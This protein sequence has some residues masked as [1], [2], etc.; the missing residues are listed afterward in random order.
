MSC[1]GAVK[2]VVM[3]N[4]DCLISADLN[5]GFNDGI[6]KADGIGECRKRVFKIFQTAATMGK[7]CELRF[8]A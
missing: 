4:V 7:A 8:V 2:R 1:G 5:I 3:K 6:A